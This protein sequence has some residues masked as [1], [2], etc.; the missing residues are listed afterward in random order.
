MRGPRVLSPAELAAVDDPQTLLERAWGLEPA[1]RLS[2][3]R[4]AL[5]RLAELLEDASPPSPP[6]R[7]W[8]LELLAERAIDASADIR[9]AEASALAEQVLAGADPT[10]E[11][12]IVRALLA[13]GRALA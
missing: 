1:L 3:R 5:A 11:I 7:D 10:H 13:Q 6:G 4:A 9:L 2:E 12:A 8:R